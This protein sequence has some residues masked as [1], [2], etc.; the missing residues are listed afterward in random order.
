[1]TVSMFGNFFFTFL[2]KDTCSF[3]NLIVNCE[4]LLH[5]THKKRNPWVFYVSSARPLIWCRCF[6]KIDTFPGNPWCTSV[7]PGPE[8]AAVALRAVF[9]WPCSRWFD[10]RLL[11]S[12]VDIFSLGSHDGRLQVCGRVKTE[13]HKV[14]KLE[15]VIIIF[16][17]KYSY[18]IFTKAIFTFHVFVANYHVYCILVVYIHLSLIISVLNKIRDKIRKIA[19]KELILIIIPTTWFIF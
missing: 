6:I 7:A 5:M 19:L 8:R 3:L 13:H 1:M 10:S 14:E 11:W 17:L 15:P 9:S 2:G 4:T 16:R 12:R 18:L